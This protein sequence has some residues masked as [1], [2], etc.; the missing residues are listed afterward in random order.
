MVL[1]TWGR[2][3]GRWMVGKEKENKGGDKLYDERFVG[4]IETLDE[5]F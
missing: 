1:E 2:E 4:E 3:K 5:R